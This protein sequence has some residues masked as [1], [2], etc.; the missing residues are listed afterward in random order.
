M[1][2]KISKKASAIR[3]ASLVVGSLSLLSIA[4]NQ[5]ANKE[6]CVS[7]FYTNQNLIVLS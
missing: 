2:K 6:A 1:S 3:T 4:F 5:I 7:A